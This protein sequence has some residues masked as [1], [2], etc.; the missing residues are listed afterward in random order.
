MQRG[1]LY[2]YA[3]TECML[4]HAC[5]MHDA[6][7]EF[8]VF[9]LQLHDVLTDVVISQVGVHAWQHH[10][11]AYISLVPSSMADVMDVVISWS[12]FYRKFL[13]RIDSCRWSMDMC[14]Y[15]RST[16]ESMHRHARTHLR[17]HI[18]TRAET[19]GHTCVD[20]PICHN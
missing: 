6:Y 19:H 7:M 12:V 3:H 20:R 4:L 5:G 14:A 18:Y 16:C 10:R 17:T 15:T 8:L 13:D 11:L 1:V 2:L 9:S